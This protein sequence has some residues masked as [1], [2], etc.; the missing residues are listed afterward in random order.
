MTIDEPLQNHGSTLEA[1]AS[2]GID[3]DEQPGL[4][5]RINQYECQTCGHI[6]TTIDRDNGTTPFLI[7]CKGSLPCSSQSGPVRGRSGRDL[8]Q[9]KCYGSNV[10]QSAVPTHE[11]YRPELLDGLGQQ[12]VLSHVLAGGLLLREINPPS[13]D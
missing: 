13:A 6:T 3:P 12:G 2:Q 9:S 1:L 10:D 5:G 8:A 7:E 4:K 11:W